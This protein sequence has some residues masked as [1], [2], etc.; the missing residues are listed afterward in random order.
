MKWSVY[1]GSEQVTNKSCIMYA[2]LHLV[3][4]RN[5]SNVDS[6]DERVCGRTRR[7]FGR[8]LNSNN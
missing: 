3:F 1:V 5:Q 6:H 4:V 2:L 8:P 7:C